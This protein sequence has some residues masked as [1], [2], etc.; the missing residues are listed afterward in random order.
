MFLTR[1]N[2]IRYLK[3]ACTIVYNYKILINTLTSYNDHLQT[4]GNGKRVYLIILLHAKKMDTKSFCLYKFR[5]FLFG[6][7]VKFYNY[8]YLREEVIYMTP[9]LKELKI[10]IFLT[11]KQ[12]WFQFTN[13]ILFTKFK[14]AIILLECKTYSHSLY[15]VQT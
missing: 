15:W 4:L 7:R 3:N 10:Y 14:E 11:S 1:K 13:L 5:W 9:S 8:L 2:M 6:D 12:S